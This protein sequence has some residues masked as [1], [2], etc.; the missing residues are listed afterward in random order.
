MEKKK[1]LQVLIVLVVCILAGLCYLS[2]FSI[3][4]GQSTL[5]AYPIILYPNGSGTSPIMEHVDKSLIANAT[6]L[7]DKDFTQFPVIAEAITGRRDVDRGFSKIGGVTPGEESVFV[8]KY[9]ISEYEGKYYVLL[10]QLH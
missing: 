3:Q 6:H 4:E 10:V 8:Q 2:W 5:H 9:Y 1:V 7:S